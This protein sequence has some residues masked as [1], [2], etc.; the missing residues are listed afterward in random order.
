VK[1]KEINTKPNSCTQ[2]DKQNEKSNGAFGFEGLIEFRFSHGRLMFRSYQL[3]CFHFK[4]FVETK[5]FAGS[6]L[7]DDVKT[8]GA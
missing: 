7:A 4:S 3:G 6:S 1:H 5:V 8:T 2:N